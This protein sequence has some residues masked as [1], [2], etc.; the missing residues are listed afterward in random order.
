MPRH[1]HLKLLE[2]FKSYAVLISNFLP[3]NTAKYL[4]HFLK[5]NF[6]NFCGRSH[7]HSGGD[8]VR[9]YVVPAATFDIISGKNASRICATLYHQL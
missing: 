4:G 5:Q 7:H 2:P 3:Y 8:G 1:V 9:R 6:D